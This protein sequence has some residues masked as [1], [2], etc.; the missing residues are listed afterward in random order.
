MAVSAANFSAISRAF[1][2]PADVNLS[3]NVTVTLEAAPDT[4]G[5]NGNFGLA[6]KLACSPSSLVSWPWNTTASTGAYAASATQ[7]AVQ[8]GTTAAL[9]VTGCTAGAIARIAV[10]R[11]HTVASDSAATADLFAVKLNYTGM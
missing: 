10:A 2:I 6:V 11:D 5:A 7:Y 3:A 9:P 1:F 8:A 4:A